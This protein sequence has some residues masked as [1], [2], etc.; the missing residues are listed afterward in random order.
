MR[1]PR[2]PSNATR[3]RDA[4]ACAVPPLEPTPPL[5]R[6]APGCSCRASSAAHCR[7]YRS[8]LLR[9]R[10]THSTARATRAQS[11]SGPSSDKRRHART[12]SDESDQRCTRGTTGTRPRTASCSS[13]SRNRSHTITDGR[14]VKTRSTSAVTRGTRRSPSVV[15]I[16]E[17]RQ[18]RIGAT[19]HLVACLL[20]RDTRRTRAHR[21]G[22]TAPATPQRG[23][24][25]PRAPR[26]AIDAHHR[27]PAP[28]RDR[29]R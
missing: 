23:R 16:P 10:E 2:R 17:R 4:A 18:A 5:H 28:R 29:T 19:R 14:H 3:H 8:R 24:S 12:S 21:D 7:L 11:A 9:P 25:R 13:P 26:P 20:V 27:T 15:K 1:S 6:R 22:L